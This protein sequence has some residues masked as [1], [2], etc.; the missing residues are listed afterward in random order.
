MAFLNPLFAFQDHLHDLLLFVFIE[1]NPLFLILKQLDQVVSLFI[2]DIQLLLQ[3]PQLIF[4]VPILFVQVVHPLLEILDENC[5]LI[6]FF[7]HALCFLFAFQTQLVMR[8]GNH[9]N[10]LIQHLALLLKFVFQLL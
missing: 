8:L 1:R 2:P 3:D 6:K 10:L 9:T 5:L 7:L 4:L